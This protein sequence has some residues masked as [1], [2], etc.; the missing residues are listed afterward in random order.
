MKQ[1]FVLFLCLGCLVGCMPNISP[2]TY[3]RNEVGVVGKA[4]EGV[5]IARRVVS[6]DNNSGVGALAGTIGGGAIGSQ[7]G[8]SRAAHIVGAVGAG[9]LGGTVGNAVD[10]T[11]NNRMGYEYIIR[12]E[13]GKSISIVQEKSV[14]LMV[15]QK[16]TVIQGAT[17]ARIIPR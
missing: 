4:Y 7:V 8:G 1:I 17:T 16:V 14:Q 11:F 10:R 3:G 6:I 15:G 5:V 12:L 9:V 13:N 2:N